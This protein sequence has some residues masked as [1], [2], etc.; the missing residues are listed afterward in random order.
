M[1]LKDYI[2]SRDLGKREFAT[3]IG[4]SACALSNYLYHRRR[5][6]LDIAQRIVKVTKGKVTIEDLLLM[7]EN[8][9]N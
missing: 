6:R 5:P 2:E 8:D 9:T 3:M 7:D 4:I 1:N